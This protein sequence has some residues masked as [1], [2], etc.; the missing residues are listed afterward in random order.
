MPGQFDAS[1]EVEARRRYLNYA[2]SVITSRAL[3]DVRDGLKPVQ[4]RILYAMLHDNYLRPDAKHRKSATVVGNVLGKYHPHG[5]SSVYDA[6]VRMAQDWVLRV[7]FV[8][9]SGNFGSIDGDEAAAYRYTECRLA[10]PAMELL[11]ELDFDT[12]DMRANYDG[13]TEEPTVLPARFPNLL[14][15]GS[16]GIAVGM[17]T[18]IPPHNLR[19]ITNA[20]IAIIVARA[21]NRDIDHVQLMKHIDGPD[22][23]TGG[24]LLNSKVELRQIYKDGQGTLRVRGEYKLE[25]KKKGGTDIVITSIP[26]ALTK[27]VLVEKIAEV[28]IARKLPFLLD[29]RDESTTD[30]R[31]VLEIKKDADPELVMAYLYKQTPL[32]A[33]FHVNMTCLVPP[34]FLDG[35]APAG[36]PPQPKRMGIKEVLEHFL[37]FRLIVTQRRFEYQLKQLEARIHLLE[38]FATIFDA[39]DELIKIIRASDGKEDAANKIIK[40]FKL[41][42]LQTDAILELK[43]YKLAKLEINLIREELA[44]KGAE[45]KKIRT[46]LKSEDKLWAVIKDE[47]KAVAEQLGTPR[48]TKTGGSNE[49]VTFDA[50]A[51]IVDEDANVVVTNDGW[52][53]RVRELKDPNATRVREGDAV[54][55]VLPGSTKEKVIFFT[56]RGSAYVIKI[57]DIAATTGYGDPAQKYFKFADGEKI[58][59][60]RTLDPRAMVPVTLLAMTKRGYGL[61]FASTAHQEVTTKVGRRYAK[62]QEG[63][64]VLGVVPCNDGDV[65]VAATRTGYV[66]HCKADEIAKLENPGRGVTVIKTAD[67]DAV[68][69][70]IAGRKADHLTIVTEKSGKEFSLA[71]DP[72]QVKGRGGKGHQVM[73]RVTFTVAPTP[74]TIQPLANAEGGQGVN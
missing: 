12:V 31:I 46:I 9:G 70:F 22:F 34:E 69:G 40:R 38:G 18:N 6:M 1:L 49:E 5:D 15:N 35:N 10:P 52:I 61:R 72:K 16:T 4:R 17:A 57:N 33:N 26:Y 43:L 30:I 71:A 27:S 7:P 58:V 48:R 55:H 54:A 20:L 29:V 42:E 19:E 14:V 65:V 41:D 62:P 32:Q 74:V 44:Q 50:D 3:P 68:I 13:T 56:N 2:L 45:A 51:F 8:D 23:P 11:R 47:L 25:D 63:D 64:E 73:K 39:L 66:L 59:A 28:I 37:D 60:A 36:S 24:Q 67:D 53:K 21:E